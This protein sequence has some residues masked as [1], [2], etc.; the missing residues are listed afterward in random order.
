MAAAA[1][2]GEERRFGLSCGRRVGCRQRLSIY[3][4]KLTDTALRALET[5]ERLAVSE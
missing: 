3:H 2:L 5:Y 4:L 1:A